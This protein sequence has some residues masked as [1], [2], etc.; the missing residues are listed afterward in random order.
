MKTQN[1]RWT[2]TPREVA[3]QTGLHYT[4]ILRKIRQGTLAATKSH[5][6]PKGHWLIRAESIDDFLNR[7]GE[8]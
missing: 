8:E 5:P 4:T 1:K 3:E 6:S 2:Y 7:R